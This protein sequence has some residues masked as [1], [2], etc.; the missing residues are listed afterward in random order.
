MATHGDWSNWIADAKAV[1]ILQVAQSLGAR[2]EKAGAAE[3]VGP[4]P[5][6]GGTDRFSINV[7]K[8]VFNCR[9][10]GAK[11]DVI[12]MVEEFSGCSFNEAC[13]WLTGRPR[14]DNSRDETEE[15][16]QAR[17][18]ASARREAEAKAR[19]EAQERAEAAKARLDEQHID[20]VLERAGP[21]VESHMGMAHLEM[22]G[23]AMTSPR[24]L[25][26]IRFVDRLE[27]WGHR[28]NGDLYEKPVVLAVLPAVIGLIRDVNGG[29]IGLA[30]KYLDSQ[31]LKKW[32]PSG[33]RRNSPRKI[34]GS[35][36]H[37]LIRL[38]K[39]GETVALSEGW[40][41][42]LSYLALGLCDSQDVTFAAAVDLGNLAGR[43]IGTVNHPTEKNANGAK[44]SIPQGLKPDP[45]EP[46]VILP[47][48]VRSIILLGDYDSEKF[49]TAAKMMTAATRFRANGI[50]VA[51]SWPANGMDF[52][53]MLL[54]GWVR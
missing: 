6:C 28:D 34:R 11:G 51:L 3:W 45:K 23:L 25:T 54:E 26:D 5:V 12:S 20:D 13:E 53:K 27:Y 43:A 9:G 49:F 31:T 50:E 7:H 15:E 47:D 19:R 14:P 38:G 40:E 22:L 42:A 33:S 39:I 46:G 10:C 32:I 17:L 29:V 37:G 36:Q 4:C 21:I 52:N 30:E 2:L 24:L 41:N 35:K 8:R 1:N 18:N 44:T 16:R 48:G